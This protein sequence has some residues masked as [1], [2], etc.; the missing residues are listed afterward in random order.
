MDKNKLCRQVLDIKEVLEVK[1]SE[2]I[3]TLKNL[4]IQEKKD[5]IRKLHENVESK[6][7]IIVDKILES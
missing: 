3:V 2:N 7:N 6:F 5:I 4:S 1:I